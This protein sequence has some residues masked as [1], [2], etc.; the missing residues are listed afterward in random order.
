MKDTLLTVKFQE[1]SLKILH[2]SMMGDLVEVFHLGNV[3]RLKD[4]QKPLPLAAW[5]QR[6]DVKEY[7]DFLSEK[8]GKPSIERRRGKNGGTFAHLNIL[9]DAATS[10]SPSFKHEVYE[11]FINNRLLN[12]RDS[13]GDSFKDM[14]YL[15]ALHAEKV[16]GKPAHVGHFTYVAKAIRNKIL[17]EN[18]PG[19]D[20]ADAYQLRQRLTL[21]EKVTTLLELG[22]VRDWDH[23][24]ELMV[25]INP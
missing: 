17:P 12:F 8:L 9:I 18:H 10:L 13:S 5:I 20:M 16:L 14:N 15:L 1:G 21:E 25:R 7:V 19:W 23:L 11:T 3:Y 24:K 2:K 6:E 4:G 22:V